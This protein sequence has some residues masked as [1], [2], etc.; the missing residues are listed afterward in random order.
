MFDPDRLPLSSSLPQDLD[1]HA[2]RPG[3]RK[4]GAILCVA[5]FGFLPSCGRATSESIEAPVLGTSVTLAGIEIRSAEGVPFPLSAQTADGHLF[6]LEQPATRALAGNAAVLDLFAGVGAVDSVF[7]SALRAPEHSI[8]AAQGT[9]FDHVQLVTKFDTENVIGLAPDLAL[10]H[11][12]QPIEQKVQWRRTGLALIEL[13]DV[14]SFEDTVEAL[15]LVA[16]LTGR[17]ETFAEARQ[18]LLER[19]ATLRERSSGAGHS[20]LSYTNS[21]TGG[22]V[23]GRGTT[24]HAVFDLVG[25][26]NAG[27]KW[28]GHSQVEIEDLLQL[29]PDWL[30]LSPAPGEDESRTYAFLKNEPRMQS[31]RALKEERFL[32]VDG[33]L[34]AS[35]SHHILDAAAVLDEQLGG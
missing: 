16:R 2:G 5:L 29:D 22:W 34:W 17:T 7:A 8:A 21:G 13:P 19:A 20:A 3:S 18:E 4:L 6:R 1:K 12:W 28:K 24:A 26:E 32:R 31:L 9:S 23:A 15:D 10:V 25:L 14:T 33:T 27:T 11:G 30:V 35:N